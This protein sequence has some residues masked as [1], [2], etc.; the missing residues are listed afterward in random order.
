[1]ST[2][3]KQDYGNDKIGTSQNSLQVNLPLQL[4][5]LRIQLRLWLQMWCRFSPWPGNF[6]LQ[7]AQSKMKIKNQTKA[8]QSSLVLVISNSQLL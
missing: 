4:S 6:H 8:N 3:K 5:R 2:G 7:K 1:M